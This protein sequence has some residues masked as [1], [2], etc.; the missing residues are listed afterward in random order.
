[1]NLY[2]FFVGLVLLGALAGIVEGCRSTKKISKAMA[3]PSVRP[4]TT[5]TTVSVAAPVRDLHADSMQVIRQTLGQ[6]AKNRINFQTFSSKMH[7]HYEESDGKDY[8]VNAFIH[9]KKDSMIW[10]VV[11]LAFGLEAFRMMITPDSVKVLDKIKKIARLRSVNY[12]KESKSICRWI[13]GPC[14]TC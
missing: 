7:V 11:N 2:K 12:L 3:I 8:E 9:I 13:S 4:D 14:R 6:L 10:I 5:A 1:M